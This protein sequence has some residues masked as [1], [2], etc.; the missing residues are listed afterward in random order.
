MCSLSGV[1]YDTS[2]WWSKWSTS[3]MYLL[4]LPRTVLR[5][6]KKA[7]LWVGVSACL[8]FAY[9]CW[10]WEE[11]DLRSGHLEWVEGKREL[12][13]P[14]WRDILARK[15]HHKAQGCTLPTFDPWGQEVKEYVSSI[16][17]VC[18]T[19]AYMFNSYYI[20]HYITTGDLLQHPTQ[21]AVHAL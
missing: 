15:G 11:P 14:D 12:R 8:V 3:K 21:P 7:I 19:A 16:P 20:K 13:S 2:E 9:W 1:I 5:R 10:F 17:E 18:Y 6:H 4:C